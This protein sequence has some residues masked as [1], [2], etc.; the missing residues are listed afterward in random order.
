MVSTY[1]TAKSMMIF[2]PF[3]EG[4][5]KPSAIDWVPGP[6]RWDHA[7]P[8]LVLAKQYLCTPSGNAEIER[9]FNTA[10]DI[11][12]DERNRLLPG[13]VT[14]AKPS[15]CLVMHLKCRKNSCGNIR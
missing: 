12:N 10:A 14:D 15:E 5:R 1:S 3:D 7:R 6:G 13:N 9:K 11:A 4:D 2:T 8:C